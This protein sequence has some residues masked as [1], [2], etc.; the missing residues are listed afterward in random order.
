MQI[1][2]LEVFI[3]NCVYVV[4]ESK[5]DDIGIDRNCDCEGNLEEAT[6]RQFVYGNS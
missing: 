5:R 4:A 3:A 2:G 6:M 1:D